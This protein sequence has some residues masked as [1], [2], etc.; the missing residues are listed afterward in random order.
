MGDRPVLE[1]WKAIAAYLGRTEKTCRKWEHELGLPVHRLDS[2]VKAHVFAYADEIDAWK[3]KLEGAKERK[4]ERLFGIFA[5]SRRAKPWLGAVGALIIIVFVGFLVRQSTQNGRDQAGTR[6]AKGI[7]ILPFVDLSPDKS[8]E[9]VAD[10]IADILINTLNRIEGLSIPAR[11]S[12]FYFKGKDVTTAE[13]G[14]KLNVDWLL[15]GSV[16]IEGQRLRVTANL[17]RAADGTTV[18]AD[19]YDRERV[20]IFSV[21]DEIARKVADNLKVKVMGGG[22]APLTRAGT[23]DVEAYNQFLRGRHYAEKGRVFL[24]QAIE[25]FEKAVERDPQYVDA[26]AQI[27]NCYYTLGNVGYL[28]QDDA[29]AK[30]RQAAERALALDAANADALGTLALIKLTYELDFA[31]A[32]ED[33]RK[34]VDSHPADARLRGIFA[35]F[36]S[37][38]GRHDEAIKETQYATELDPLSTNTWTLLAMVGYYPAGE[39]DLAIEALK[40]SVE[41]NP[42][43]AGLQVNLIGVYLAMGR[44]VD[45]RAA[46]VRKR[47]ILSCTD[48]PEE[49]DSY[50]ALTY[51]C[52]GNQ[53]MARR[54]LARTKERMTFSYVCPVFVIAWIHAALGDKDEAFAWLDKAVEEREIILHKLKVA[55][56]FESLHS[57]PRFTDLLRRIGLE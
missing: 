52:A 46:N 1:S 19:R 51:A 24:R 32:G 34:A 33:I 21:E 54:I 43:D 36:F 25:C 15:E 23:Q 53:P 37:A 48:C 10:G 31:G 7:A 9:H 16:Q 26:H 18:W 56:E 50:F 42:F 3:E 38:L 55:P 47:E 39:Y 5:L 49:D 8:Q 28:R 41:L 12:A 17:L 4:T 40:K 30:A 29:C 6:S 35:R 57:D 11:T 13:I 20:D 22:R 2:S 14:R 27:S 45:A 44:C